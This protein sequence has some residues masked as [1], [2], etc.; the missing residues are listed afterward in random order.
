MGPVRH[1]GTGRCGLRPRTGRA[2]GRRDV[3]PAL[4]SGGPDRDRAAGPRTVPGR[5]PPRVVRRAGHRAVERAT[6]ETATIAYSGDTDY[7]A[8]LVEGARDVDLLLCEAAF[9]EGRDD[10]V[11]PGIHLTGRG[12][13]R[14]AR[15][16]GAARL[17]L[18]HVP[19]WN[20]PAVT[21]VEARSEY[22]G[23]L[24]VTVSGAT[25]TV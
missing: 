1:R 4:G 10:G 24:E 12:A 16:A 7:C 13:G 14:V 6:G 20:D 5:P 9:H 23:P 11:D 15:E 8:S 25:Y 3:L 21:V 22:D 17:V 19:A 18:T 2:H